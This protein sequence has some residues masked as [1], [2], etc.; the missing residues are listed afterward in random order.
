MTNFLFT[1][2]YITF[3]CILFIAFLISKIDDPYIQNLSLFFCNVSAIV[4]IGCRGYIYSDWFI[5]ATKFDKYPIFPD[6]INLIIKAITESSQES[7]FVLFNII[8]KSIYNDYLF[9]QFV[10][11]IFEIILLNL[12]LKRYVPKYYIL[13]FLFY[14]IFLGMTY[15]FILIRNIKAILLFLVSIRYI[16]KKQPVK[17]FA[18]NTIGLL[19]HSSAI[20]YFPLYFFINKRPN[21]KFILFIYFT[22]LILFLFQFPIATN[23]FSLLAD[24]IGVGRYY[25]LI[26]RYL[27]SSQ[28]SAP[29]GISIGLIERVFSFLFIFYH[30]KILYEKSLIFINCFY[31]YSFIFVW[32]SDFGIIF[33]R[34]GALFVFSY[35]VLYINIY[36]ILSKKHKIVFLCLFLTFSLLRMIV[37]V[38]NPDAKYEN[39]FTGI[40]SRT[41]R[42]AYV[43]PFHNYIGKIAD[44]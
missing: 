23:I 19:F 40:M 43:R 21:D 20:I 18:L 3:F 25:G 33:D 6:G 17:Y 11:F 8:C 14:F 1:I 30:R 12:I 10:N 44:Y 22:G 31:I 7:A 39:I 26:I 35:C 29:Y 15:S 16:E 34:M 13:G 27:N 5:Y 38:N 9:F 28:W 37:S 41:E 2:P 36:S 24:L 4:F 42:R 32:L